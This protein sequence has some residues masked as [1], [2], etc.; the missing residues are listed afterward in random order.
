[1]NNY[2][3][4]RK[5]MNLCQA[6]GKDLDR[7]GIYCIKC[8]EIYNNLKHNHMMKIHNQNKCT[9]CSKTMDREGWLCKSCCNK[10]NKR[11]KTRSQE[12][13]EKGLCVQ[14]GTPITEFIYCRK[15]LDAR[16]DRYWKK[17]KQ[18]MEE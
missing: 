16:M 9:T 8:N 14:C 3:V 4:K 13:R 5:E 18:L 7:K 1:M 2:K 6:C 10:L 15:C 11:G 17:K 12:R